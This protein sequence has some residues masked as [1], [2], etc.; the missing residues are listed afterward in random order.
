MLLCCLD[1]LW[2]LPAAVPRRRRCSRLSFS[3][4]FPV[5]L[6]EQERSVVLRDRA[7]K[8][9]ADKQALLT[10]AKD[11]V[12]K[13]YTDRDATLAK[14]QKTNR[15]DEKNYRADMKATFESGGQSR[16]LRALRSLRCEN[17]LFEAAAAKA[18]N[19]RPAIVPTS[20]PLAFVAPCVCFACPAARWEKVNKLVSTAPRAGEK[21]GT[22]RVERMRKLLIQLKAE[23]KQ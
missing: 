9:E 1:R 14:Q 19:L 8:A 18:V 21:A 23:K 17:A 20:S 7:A 13:F 4:V 6:W 22:S 2:S 15:A 10:G 16:D 12:N 11:E 3:S 5:R